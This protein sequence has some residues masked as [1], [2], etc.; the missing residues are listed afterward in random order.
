[1]AAASGS[2]DPRLERVF[3]EVPREAF[4][5]PGPWLIVVDDLIFETPDSDPAHLYQDA[6]VVI[7]AEKGINNGQPF[8]HAAWIG[9]ALPQSGETVTHVGAGTGYYTAVLAALVAPGGKVTAFEIEEDLAREAQRHLEPYGVTVIAGD[10]TAAALPQSDLIYVNAA[11][12]APPAAWLS[13][14]TDGGRM[15]F[16][17]QPAGDVGLTLLVT[18]RPAGF[19]VEP[20]MSTLFIRCTG[21]LAF[22]DCTMTPGRSEARSVRSVWVAA[23]RPPDATAVAVCGEVWF[24]SAELMEP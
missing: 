24:S 14:L 5:P 17:W 16:P 15:I 8:L 4:L 10:A 12:A 13:A 19:A 21:A 1:M 7:D 22:R 9:A 6:L 18:R 23:E 20:L 3:G 11:M 2:R